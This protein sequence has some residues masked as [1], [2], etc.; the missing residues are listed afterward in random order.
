MNAFELSRQWFD[1]AFENPSKITPSHGILYFFCIEH[2]NR[3]GW[4]KEFG[5]PTT[6]AKEAIGIR[7][8]T[9]YIKVLND[10]VEWGFILLIEKSKNQYSSNIIALTIFDKAT[11]KALDKAMI[12]HASKQHESTGE[13]IVSI[14]KPITIEPKTINIEPKSSIEYD[15]EKIKTELKEN[16]YTTKQFVIQ[17]YKLTLDQYLKFVDIFV[18][19]KD[20]DLHKPLDEVL[21][22]FKNWVR[23]NH[24]KLKKD[25]ETQINNPNVAQ[26]PKKLLQ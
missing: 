20:N 17:Q 22:H 13:S 9:T 14:D 18:G 6:M 21:K 1:F 7:S 23:T 10:L 25:F 11:V 2:C 12:K 26:L 3:L 8:Y 16:Q 19:E 4:K 15:F 24:V 5:L